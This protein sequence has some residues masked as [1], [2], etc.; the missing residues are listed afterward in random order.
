MRCR[1]VYSS[2]AGAGFA[3]EYEDMPDAIP[4]TPRISEPAVTLTEDFLLKIGTLKGRIGYDKLV[5]T[6]T[7]PVRSRSG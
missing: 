6:S 3:L 7:C 1:V 4:R 2:P 5:T